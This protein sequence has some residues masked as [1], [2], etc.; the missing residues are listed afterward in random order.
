MGGFDWGVAEGRVHVDGVDLEYACFGPAPDRAPTLV[1]LHEGLG[2]VALWRDV[3]Q[4]L[5]ERTGFGVFVYS[6]RGYGWSD[7]AELPRPLD[8][9][10]H[11]GAVVLPALLDS[12]G[13]QRGVLLGHSDGAT[14]A[15]IHAGSVVD[16][17]VRGLI[18]IAPHFFTEEMGLAQISRARTEFETTDMSGRMAKYHADP[19]TVFRG[20]S[21]VWLHPDFKA[22]NVGEVIDYFRIPTLA[23]QG[24]EDEY[25]TLAQIREIEERSYAP[26][27][28][29]LLEDCGHSPHLERKDEVL[30]GIGAFLARL[31]RIEAAEVELA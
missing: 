12:I 26:L 22:W 2:S 11:E 17:R 18:L 15:A 23:I 19:E 16:H 29:L 8:F 28:T 30:A 21:D 6:R 5:A 9:M 20:W 14:I 25:G 4:R 10:T 3:P 7:P 31:E 1:L 27:D 13:F 24:C